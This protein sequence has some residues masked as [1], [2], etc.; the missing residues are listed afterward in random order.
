M[1]LRYSIQKCIEFLDE[2]PDLPEGEFYYMER[3]MSLHLDNTR[4]K[5]ETKEDDLAEAT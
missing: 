3:R 4:K 2:G 1:M 5:F